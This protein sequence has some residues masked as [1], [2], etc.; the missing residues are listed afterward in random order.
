MCF[1]WQQ[2]YKDLKNVSRFISRVFALKNPLKLNHFKVVSAFE[3]T[4]PRTCSC[5]QGFD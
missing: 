5:I 4:M 3:K 1:C 2:K